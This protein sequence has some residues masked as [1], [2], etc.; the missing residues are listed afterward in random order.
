M[1]KSKGNSNSKVSKS[2][3]GNSRMSRAKRALRRTL[4]KIARWERNQDDPN[5]VHTL[6]KGK[7]VRKISRYNEWNVDGLKKHANLQR[8]IIKR[9]RKTKSM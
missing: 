8:E 5:K 3:S 7:K 9:G 6:T 4:M 2:S 1:G